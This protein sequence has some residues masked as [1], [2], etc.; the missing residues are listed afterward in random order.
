[1]VVALSASTDFV[2][3]DVAETSE[4]LFLLVECPIFM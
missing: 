2:F 3:T 4:P 1:M